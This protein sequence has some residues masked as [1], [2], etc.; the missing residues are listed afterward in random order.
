MVVL[1]IAFGMVIP[2][3]P[4]QATFPD[5]NGRIAFR[6]WFDADQTWGAIFTINPDGTGERQVTFPPKGFVDRNP[7]IS[8]DGTR[9]VFER[10]AIDC[11]GAPKCFLVDVFVVDVDGSNL[12]RLTGIRPHGDC[13][14]LSGK[15]SGTPAWSPDG[16]Q[17]AFS[18]ASGPVKND[19]VERSAIY[20]MDADG[21]NVHRVTQRH[22]PATGED[23]EPQ[24][25]PDGTELLFQRL[26][27][28][29]ATP[30]DGVALWVK[31]LQTGAERRI[32]PWRLHAGDTPDWS[33][34]GKKVL[35]HSNQFG[36]PEI[37]GNLF[38]VR[39]SGFHPEKLT[40][41][42]GGVRQYLGS[43]YSP[44]GK[45]IVFGRRP[46]TGGVDAN[47]ADVFIMRTDGSHKRHVTRTP[48]YDSYPDWGPAID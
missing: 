42:H 43:S 24:F 34:D 36:P 14:P 23:S 1:L 18:Q 13:F 38:T 37:S 44:D 11:D 32:T 47:A 17:I 9:I 4:A 30:A 40:F 31:D 22:L 46:A 20:I 35:F 39:A 45:W 7:D 33:P 2:M 3:S 5:E 25:S 48:Q 21:S 6:R 29:S 10:Q 8:P 12:T 19:L 16:T 26:N 15:C 41:A 27:V 28:R